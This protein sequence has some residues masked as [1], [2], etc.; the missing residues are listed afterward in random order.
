MCEYLVVRCDM[1]CFCKGFT[2]SGRPLYSHLPDVCKNDCYCI[3]AK[4]CPEPKDFAHMQ[5]QS[6]LQTSGNHEY[7]GRRYPEG[8]T[9]KGMASKRVP[10]PTNMSLVMPGFVI[11]VYW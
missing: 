11:R 3:W 4:N 9:T 1:A 5:W 6:F 2:F 10:P 8:F 7:S